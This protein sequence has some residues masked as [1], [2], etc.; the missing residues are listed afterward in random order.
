M[1]LSV[2]AGVSYAK[3]SD[4]FGRCKHSVRIWGIPILSF[5]EASCESL[6]LPFLFEDVY[7]DA[8]GPRNARALAGSRSTVTRDTDPDPG[9]TKGRLAERLAS[10]CPQFGVARFCSSQLGSAS[11]P[12]GR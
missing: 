7:E 10:L 5:F 2:P 8:S 11:S 6:L 12:D 3:M 1:L 4:S 9:P